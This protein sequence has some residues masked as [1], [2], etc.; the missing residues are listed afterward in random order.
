MFVFIFFFYHHILD[1][2]IQTN[3]SGCIDE[4]RKQW[5]HAFSVLGKSQWCLITVF[6]ISLVSVQNENFCIFSWNRVLSKSTQRTQP[7]LSKYLV[8]RLKKIKTTHV[9][10][11]ASTGMVLT[12]DV[13]GP[14]SGPCSASLQTEV[15]IPDSSNSGKAGPH[16]SISHI[17]SYFS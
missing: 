14:G 10:V 17:P 4:F 16:T 3:R 15:F 1:T 9:C 5:P 13:E 2:F 12:W 7:C 11:R 6:A 8:L